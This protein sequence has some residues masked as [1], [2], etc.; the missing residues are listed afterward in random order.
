MTSRWS[1]V[2]L[3]YFAMELPTVSPTEA[4][5]VF[6]LFNWV[7]LSLYDRNSRMLLS[8]PSSD[9]VIVIALQSALLQN[10]LLHLR[11]S[12]YSFSILKELERACDI[13]GLAV[14]YVYDTEN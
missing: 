12:L 5:N 2:T 6:F 9:E 14:K 10:A 7:K 1:Y 8:L 4:A 11:N 3:A 13:R